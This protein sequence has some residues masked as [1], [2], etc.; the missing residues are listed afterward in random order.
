MKRLDC[1]VAAGLL[2]LYPEDLV[3]PETKGWMERHLE[4]CEACRRK[5]ARLGAFA[6]RLP[7]R[8]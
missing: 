1:S 4:R 5:R 3:S 2:L 7:G 8:M 6:L